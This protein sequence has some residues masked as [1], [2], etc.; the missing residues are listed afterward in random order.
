MALVSHL[1]WGP[2]A[3]YPGSPKC[4]FQ[5]LPMSTANS[6]AVCL[7]PSSGRLWRCCEEWVFQRSECSS[8]GQHW[9]TNA[10]TEE[11]GVLSNPLG[12]CIP[13]WLELETL[14]WMGALPGV[15][16]TEYREVLNHGIFF[17]VDAITDAPLPPLP[18]SALLHLPL[19]TPP[20]HCFLCPWAMP[21]CSLAHLFQ[22]PPPNFFLRRNTLLT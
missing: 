12:W 2:G 7:A 3:L 11:E 5:K 22:S 8:A 18:S 6:A 21:I 9:T 14:L 4:L 19:P 17:I 1:D 16:K 20:P 15:R 13:P 10:R